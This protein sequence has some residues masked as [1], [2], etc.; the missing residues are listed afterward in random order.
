MDRKGH[1]ASGDQTDVDAL[2]GYRGSGLSLASSAIKFGSLFVLA[3]YLTF[4]AHVNRLGIPATSSLGAERYLKEAYSLVLAVFLPLFQY[5]LLVAVLVLLV[6]LGI[7]RTKA[8]R[9]MDMIGA[10]RD[11]AF[12]SLWLPIVLLIALVV[13]TFV[14]LAMVLDQGYDVVLGA[15]VPERLGYLASW[16]FY[17]I[18]VVAA[19]AYLV[20]LVAINR[21]PAASTAWRHHRRLWRLVGWS[22]LIVFIQVPMVYGAAVKQAWYPV[23]KVTRDAAKDETM[24]GVLLFDDG[25]DLAMWRFSNGRGQILMIP[26]ST[27]S[28]SQVGQLV[29]LLEVAR[30]AVAQ[31]PV[32]ALDC[33]RW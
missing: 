32:N 23:A 18:V 10:A 13:L 11:S 6:R 25:G 21:V 3:G 27:V 9:A 1:P 22:L 7:N 19:A 16:K 15:I 8:R 12:S 26:K 28:L 14:I 24:C 33:S 4:R 17:L 2:A 5:C 31:P 30:G 29:D 20:Y